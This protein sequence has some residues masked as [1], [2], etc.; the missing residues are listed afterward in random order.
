MK[1]I[2]LYQATLFK[3]IQS[4]SI[5]VYYE[6]TNFIGNMKIENIEMVIDESKPLMD[7]S[8]ETNFAV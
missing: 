7:F 2:T 8:C 6:D 1:K 4:P 5:V 3:Q